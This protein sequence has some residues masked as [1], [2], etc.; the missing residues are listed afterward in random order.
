M[1][2]LT[3]LSLLSC[4][5]GCSFFT[6]PGNFA[7]GIGDRYQQQVGDS[8]VVVYKE[9]EKDGLKF[10]Y[11]AIW[12][13]RGWDT[14]WVSSQ[15]L[16]TIVQD[17]Y[18]PLII[19]YYFGDSI[20][21]EYL[22]EN[23]QMR[24]KEWYQDIERLARLVNIGAE[25]F[26]ALEPEFNDAVFAGETPITEWEGFNDVVIEAIRRLKKGAPNCKVGL[27]AGDWGIFNLDK[28]IG[29]AAKVCDFLGFQEMRAATV[30][31]ADPTSSSY[32]NIAQSAL[33]FSHYLKRFKKPLLLAYLAVSSY[34]DGDPLGWED[35]QAKLIGGVLKAKEKLVKNGV[36]GLV[37]FSYF[38][39]PTHQTLYFGEAERFFGLKTQAGVLKKAF[40]EFNKLR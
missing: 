34:K 18:T 10:K 24:I 33:R 21:K 22:T 15:D 4:F 31:D 13:C 28:C 23:N 30:P 8:W 14:T 20:S 5:L 40:F 3:L 19:Y 26:V 6:A 2:G 39:D 29:R 37:Y 9:A 38:D 32:Q 12:L 27:V 17:G 35:E 25:V 7:L 16:K 1:I 36:F 11:V